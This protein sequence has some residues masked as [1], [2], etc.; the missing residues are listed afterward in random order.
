MKMAYLEYRQSKMKM[1]N[2]RQ[3]KQQRGE[4]LAAMAA[5]KA[6]GQRKAKIV[7]E[8]EWRRRSAK[9]ARRL[10]ARI[11]ERSGGIGVKWRL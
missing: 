10:A 2:S 5:R 4:N 6:V 1:K 3:R 7:K 9:A 8:N 11:G